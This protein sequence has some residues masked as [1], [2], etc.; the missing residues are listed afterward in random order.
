M[1]AIVMSHL[2]GRLTTLY[3]VTLQERHEPLLEELLRAMLA[4]GGHR[5]ES[6]CETRSTCVASHDHCC[7]VCLDI[8]RILHCL[9]ACQK[10]ESVEFSILCHYT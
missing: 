1:L 8:H 4:P 7:P 10:L 9:V 5:M 2:F 3:V 6:L